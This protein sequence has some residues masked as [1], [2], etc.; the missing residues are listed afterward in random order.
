[1]D[2]GELT[3]PDTVFIFNV[4]D[5]SF[6]A[7]LHFVPG[8][9]IPGG[10]GEPCDRPNYNPC[11]APMFTKFKEIGERGILVPEFQGGLLEHK[12]ADFPGKVGTLLCDH[13]C[14]QRG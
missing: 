10:G 5:V 2:S 7:P 8:E 14:S 12:D 13:D 6:C 3:L 4:N 9:T 11:A 1:M